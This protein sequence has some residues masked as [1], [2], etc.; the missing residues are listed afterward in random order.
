MATI[1]RMR[2]GDTPPLRSVVMLTADRQ[3]DRRILLQAD[4]LEAAGWAVRILAMPL[5]GPAEDDPRV[6]RV[7]ATGN[8]ARRE[9][10]IVAAYRWARARLPMNGPAMRWLKRIAWRYLVD[11]ETFYARLFLGTA[12]GYPAGIYVAHDLPMLPLARQLAQ[13]R[14]ARLVYDSHEL[15]SEQEFSSHEKRRWAEIEARHIGAC[16]LV[17]T[18]NPSIARE[19]AARYGID[20]VQVL[21]NA[22]RCREAPVPTRRFHLAFGLS[23]NKRVLLMQG[24]LSAGRNL[25]A[26]VDAMLH[27]RDPSIVLV[28]LGDGLLVDVLRARV[29][30]A[31]LEERV[32]F[33]PAVP[34]LELLAWTAAADAGVIPYQ[35]TCLNNYYCTPNKLFEFIAAGLPILASDLPEIRSMVE[36]HRIG[37]V[38][39]TGS[40]TALASL[41]DD[42]F[43][44]RQRFGAWREN[45]V[46][47]RRQVCWEVEEK[48]L[49]GLYER[50]A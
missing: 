41:I 40:P 44:D 21:L 20:G 49:I 35:A 31:G 47:A 3:I 46:E 26:L 36:G 5:D 48:H 25:E 37:M 8:T 4:S 2:D 32:R 18:V 15:Y 27:V 22:E 13:A 9:S 17:T 24:G 50:L 45:L 1:D 28:F 42:F 43:G 7:G 11:P 34:Q 14:G 19:L 23:E 6:V 16:D 38:G 30:S 29:R 33:H 10:L 12:S 39:D